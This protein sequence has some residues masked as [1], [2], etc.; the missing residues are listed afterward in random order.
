MKIENIYPCKVVVQCG[1]RTERKE[2]G[3]KIA[4]LACRGDG[5]ARPRGQV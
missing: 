3:I 2:F 1:I 5:L 4:D